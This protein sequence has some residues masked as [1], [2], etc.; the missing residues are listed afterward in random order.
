[1]LRFVLVLLLAAG[2]AADERGSP[3]EVAVAP[4]TSEEGGDCAVYL[5]CIPDSGWSP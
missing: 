2:C 4:G 1:M 3:G 5:D